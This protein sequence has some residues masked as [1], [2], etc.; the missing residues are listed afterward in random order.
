MSHQGGV[1]WGCTVVQ[2]L[3]QLAWIST[4]QAVGAPESRVQEQYRLA[5]FAEG[6]APPPEGVGAR[7]AGEAS[8]RD[9]WHRPGRAAA[10]SLPRG[11]IGTPFLA[12]QNGALIQAGEGGVPP[13]ARGVP[14]PFQTVAGQSDGAG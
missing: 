8:H 14:A 6:K 11:W 12:G 13:L 1:Q 9:R 3:C 7:A 4:S 5:P 2:F 10:E